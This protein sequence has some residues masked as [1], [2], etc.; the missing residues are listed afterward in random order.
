MTQKCGFTLFPTRCIP[1][2]RRTIGKRENTGPGHGRLRYN[3][4]VMNRNIQLRI[5]NKAAETGRSIITTGRTMCESRRRCFIT[6]ELTV[7]AVAVDRNHKIRRLARATGARASVFCMRLEISLIDR[8]STPLDNLING[9][10][11]SPAL[12]AAPLIYDICEPVPSP[13]LPFPRPRQATPRS[14]FDSDTD[15]RFRV[16]GS[17]NETILSG[18]GRLTAQTARDRA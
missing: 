7:M 3:V 11:P 18:R 14:I 6:N 4:R 13:A 10:S 5:N 17:N 9:S 15:R 1:Y 2:R 12:P 16:A 8:P